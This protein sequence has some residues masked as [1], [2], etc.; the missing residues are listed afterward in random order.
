MNRIISPKSRRAI[1]NLFADFILNKM[2]LST[3]TVIQV[4][5]CINFSV[6]NG[7]TESKSPIDTVSIIDDFNKTFKNHLEKPITHTFDF[8]KYG[9]QLEPVDFIRKK[10][11]LTS[12]N[13]SYHYSLID[14]FKLDP[15]KDYIYNGINTHSENPLINF[16]V[17]SSFPHGYSL[18]QG[19][20]LYYYSKLISYNL[21]GLSYYTQIE[22]GLPLKK[23]ENKEMEIELKCLDEIDSSDLKSYI[24]DSFDFNYE[25][26]E[27]EIMKEDL[28]KEIFNPLEDFPC[29]IE[30]LKLDPLI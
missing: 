8:I 23:N 6:I 16:S 19:R 29:V 20:T 18:P 1:T 7:I 28:Y 9:V 13:T 11:Y 2:G 26:M 17:S 14:E 25:K 27:K 5:D 12:E 22:L 21:S 24:L 10:F 30:N 4:T 3:N 15:T